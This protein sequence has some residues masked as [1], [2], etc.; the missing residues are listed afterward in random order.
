MR[1]FLALCLVAAPLGTFAQT[2]DSDREIAVAALDERLRGQSIAFYDG[3]VSEFYDDGRYTYTYAGEGGAGYGYFKVTAD[4][5]ICIEF[6]TG[7]SRCDRYVLDGEDRLVV[8]TKDG[9]RFPV[10]PEG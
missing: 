3:G 10:R 9:D 4:S 1:L 2:R 7:F 5:T 6:V 8:I